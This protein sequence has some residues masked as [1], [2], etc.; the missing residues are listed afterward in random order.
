MQ[1]VL[2]RKKVTFTRNST[3][4]PKLHTSSDESDKS[5]LP[6]N[7]RIARNNIAISKTLMSAISETDIILTP[8]SQIDIED[9]Y[10]N[11]VNNAI[12]TSNYNP[13]TIRIQV[14]PQANTFQSINNTSK[15]SSAL[16]I[17]STV[18][19]LSDDSQSIVE[20]SIQ[21]KE[22]N[23][24]N[25]NQNNN[26][27]Q[28]IEGSDELTRLRNKV[29]DYEEAIE[30]LNEELHGARE[31]IESM[32]ATIDNNRDQVNNLTLIHINKNTLNQQLTNMNT[33]LNSR[34][35]KLNEEIED[36]ELQIFL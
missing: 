10:K 7:L 19:E 6:N 9:I 5:I 17:S 33:L 36:L 8:T 22:I 26:T 3:I 20:K 34:V 24:N 29:Q 21:P 31:D 14:A 1:K 15:L 25:N 12:R 30:S 18:S 35:E 27:N 4:N 2:Q 28:I 11:Q 23:K 32:Q 13:T 16:S